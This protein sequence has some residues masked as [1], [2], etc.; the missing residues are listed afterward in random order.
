[1][2]AFDQRVVRWH[3]AR[4]VRHGQRQPQILHGLAQ[5]GVDLARE[6][7]QLFDA[8]GT[9]RE[10]GFVRDRRGQQDGVVRT[11]EGD[12]RDPEERDAERR[13]GG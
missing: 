13:Y 1:M 2:G 12:T 9:Q 11:R 8:L 10:L 6:L 3:V 5:D 7:G 4:A